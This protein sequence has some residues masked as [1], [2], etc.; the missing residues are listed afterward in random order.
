VSAGRLKA[1]AANASLWEPLHVLN[2]IVHPML[3]QF[4]A[5]FLGFYLSCETNF[6]MQVKFSRVPGDSHI[7]S[8]TS[9][10]FGIDSDYVVLIRDLFHF[11]NVANG[12]RNIIKYKWARSPTDSFFSSRYRTIDR[13]AQT[14]GGAVSQFSASVS[15][16]N[17]YH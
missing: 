10:F 16:T 13:C 9:V 2:A 6:I 3:S 8:P 12:G 1:D 17:S 11:G 5:V 7:G 4:Y 15:K 14:V